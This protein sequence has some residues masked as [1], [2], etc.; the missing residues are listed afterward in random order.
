MNY[1]QQPMYQPM[2]PQYYYPNQVPQMNTQ[3]N[4]NQNNPSEP[5]IQRTN[6]LIPVS[7]KEVARNYPVALGN[8]VS[9]KDENA[10]FIYIKTMGFSQFDKP[11][12]E[13][14]RLVKEDDE[15]ESNDQKPEEIKE[16]PHIPMV[17]ASV[18]NDINESITTLDEEL[19]STKIDIDY[20]KDRIEDL[21]KRKARV[22]K[23]KV[24][25]SDVSD[26]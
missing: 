5:V 14:L 6:E 26:E 17:E 19:K 7:D 24:G 21:G 18:I 15:F 4:Q 12:F 25:E 9:F 11:K 2:F 3:M 1:Y 16:E 23:A 22:T 20:L 10:P 8:S 13:V